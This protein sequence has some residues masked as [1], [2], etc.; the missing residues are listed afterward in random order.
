M[1]S[2]LWGVRTQKRDRDGKPCRSYNRFPAHLY[3][4]VRDSMS[5]R[6]DA[7]RPFLKLLPDGT[8]VR[9]YHGDIGPWDLAL[10]VQGGSDILAD[11]ELVPV[12]LKCHGFGHMPLSLL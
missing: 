3:A 12:E 9:L 2:W 7:L 4:C 5:K 10:V 1:P 8:K 6:W 11:G